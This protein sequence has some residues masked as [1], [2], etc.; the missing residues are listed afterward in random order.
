MIRG[1]KCPYCGCRIHPMQ[2][3]DLDA[4]E[5]RQQRVY[6]DAPTPKEI[7]KACFEFLRRR[8]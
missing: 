2:V 1:T 6:P 8:R 3:H 4:C 7:E 5:D